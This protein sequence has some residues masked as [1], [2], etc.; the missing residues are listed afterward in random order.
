MSSAL[1]VTRGDVVVRFVVV[2]RAFLGAAAVGAA[3]VGAAARSATFDVGSAAWAPE[4][5][6]PQA[7][8]RPAGG[9]ARPGSVELGDAGDGDFASIGHARLECSVSLATSRTTAC[10]PGPRL[11]VDGRRPSRGLT[12][13]PRSSTNAETWIGAETGS[14]V[15]FSTRNA[16]RPGRSPSASTTRVGDVGTVGAGDAAG[17][18]AERVKQLIDGITMRKI[19]ADP[20]Q[21]AVVPADGTDRLIEERRIGRLLHRPVT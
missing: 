15:R 3:A 9:A 14:A 2:V 12:S 1:G 10:S 8:R 18:R 21:P 13:R 6:T 7:V 4:A 17:R 16:P 5:R 20:A 11:T 19:E